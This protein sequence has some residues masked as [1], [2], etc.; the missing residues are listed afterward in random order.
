MTEP[1]EE[2]VPFRDQAAE[3]I[4]RQQAIQAQ[5]QGQ[6]QQLLEQGEGN[7]RAGERDG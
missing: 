1:I 7:V 2:Y 4:R 6:A 5:C 3:E